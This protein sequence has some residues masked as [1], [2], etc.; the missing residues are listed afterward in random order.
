MEKVL[1]SLSIPAVSEKMDVYI[2][3]FLSVK[4]IIELLVSAVEEST[5]RRYTSS[6]NERLCSEERNTI[7]PNSKTLKQCG[8]VN[9]EHLLLI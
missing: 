9:G 8:V 2:P 7:L 3:A 5:E 4:E 1:V 6:G